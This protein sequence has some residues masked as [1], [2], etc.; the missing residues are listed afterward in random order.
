[1]NNITKL[2][3]IFLYLILSFTSCKPDREFDTPTA[4]N[5]IG[6]ADNILPG[7]IRINE[8]VTTGS[9]F[10]SDLD[11]ATTSDWMELYN[12]TTDT[13]FLGNGKWS[14]TDSLEW[15]DKWV[16][17]DTFILPQSHLLIWCDD[18]D[19]VTNQLHASFKLSSG[20]E[21]LGL[22]YKKS[23]SE[24]IKVDGFGYMAQSSGVCQQRYP[25]G[26]SNWVFSSNTT[27]GYFN[28]P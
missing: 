3:P 19:T 11:S 4:Q 7:T 5:P 18:R 17:P 14:V 8:F 27:P 2:T 23:D 9:A 24:I 6:G 13:I 22:Y 1:M 28:L 16:L 20:G 26:T 12:T 15:T 10:G 21:D 25:D